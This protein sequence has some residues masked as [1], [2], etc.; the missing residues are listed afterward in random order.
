MER[1]KLDGLLLNLV[2]KSHY[3][4]LS[5]SI[6]FINLSLVVAALVTFHKGGTV[7]WGLFEIESCTHIWQREVL[8]CVAMVKFFT[9]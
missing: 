2:C 6:V 9:C 8:S 3:L 5:F 4:I 1:T 7:P